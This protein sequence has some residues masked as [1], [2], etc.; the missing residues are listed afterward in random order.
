MMYLDS[1]PHKPELKKRRSPRRRLAAAVGLLLLTLAVFLLL[2]A[3]RSDLRSPAAS[4]LLRD[5]DARFLGTLGAHSSDSEKHGLGYWPVHAIPE[6]V[7]AATLAVEDRRFRSHPGVDVKALVRA[8]FQNVRHRERVSGASTIAMQVARM[9]DPGRRTYPRK[10]LEAATALV[11][12]ARHGREAV[13]RHY[14]KIVPYSNRIRG[15]AFAARSYFDKPV[16]DLS[17]AETA[18]LAAI[19]QSPA[20]MNPFDPVGRRRAI[21][22]G[23]RILHLLAEDA[24]LT[25]VEL[26]VADDEIRRIA[27]PP[28]HRRPD[29]A[30]HAVLRFES[31]LQGGKVEGFSSGDPIVDTTLDLEVQRDV[32]QIAWQLVSSWESRG[33]G[34]AAVLV[35]DRASW[36]VVAAV[37][38]TDYFDDLHA[39]SIDYLRLPRSSGSTLKPF[40]YA[41][42]LERGVITPTTML[43]DVDRGAGGIVNSDGRFLGPLLPRVAL[44]NSRNVPAANLLDRTGLD[45]GFD[46][47][48]DLGLHDGRKSARRYGL[49]LAIGGLPVTLE[50]L[51]QAYTVLAGDGRLRELRWTKTPQRP[52]LAK[53]LLSEETVRLVTLHLCDPQARLPTFPRMGWSEFPFPVAVKTGTSSRYRDAWTVAYSSRYLAGVWVGDPDHRPM[54]R[55]SGYRAAARLMHEVMLRLHRERSSVLETPSFPPPRESKAVR[56]CALSGKRAARAC[57]RVF[58]ERLAPGEEVVNECGV[59][60]YVAVDRRDGTRA[61]SAT[62]RQDVDVRSFVDLGPK[63]AAWAS[64]AG[65][66][67]APR[68]A[69]KSL[70]DARQSQTLRVVSPRPGLR[71]LFDPETPAAMNTLA[72]K[73]VIDP[74]PEEAV[75]YVDGQPFQTV[76]RPFTA[77]WPIQPGKHTFE[78]RDA[79]SGRRSQRLEVVV[80]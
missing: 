48:E 60:R 32:E 76:G 21:E 3:G 54:R 50:K 80:E 70:T 6:R 45:V 38:S 12:T 49:G 10:A 62:P 72:L 56:V 74:M 40:L 42:A 25:P 1:H 26:A 51:V 61:S 23:R 29:Q 69:R 27:I 41:L 73:A 37:S 5:R 33:A 14:L 4:L 39:G 19:P 31:Q 78:I 36:E 57:D 17:W 66:P 46:F 71:L 13:L 63:Y 34:N 79:A 11:L 67:L 18:F 59:H 22:R 30:V 8:L 58:V 35:V 55:L 9:Q 28:R 43:D 53:R 16:A 44:A 2:A 64:R 75:W 15:I 20:R 24:T 77:R 47:L 65:L 68:D 52:V 7:V